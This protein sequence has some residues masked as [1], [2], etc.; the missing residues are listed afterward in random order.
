M[1]ISPELVNSLLKWAGLLAI[2]VGLLIGAWAALADTDGPVMRYWQRY[3]ASL[4]RKL[5][6]MFIWTPGQHIALGQVVASVVVLA[7]HV[8]IGL[9][10]YWWVIILII[11]IA[12][13]RYIEQLRKQR[14]ERIEDQ[15]DGFLTAL[16]NS[17][18]ATPSVG[19]SFISVQPLLPSPIRE[20]IE[21][22]VKEM[23]VGSTL[24]QALLNMGGRI[25]SRQLD[26]A[27]SAVLIG[28]QLGGDLPR[29][30]DTTAQTMREMI[31]L[32]GVVKTKTAEGKAQLW[33]LGAFPFI[34]AVVLST[35][36]PGFY[37]PLKKPVAG[38]AIAAVAGLSWL[39]SI[40][41]ARK[42]LSVDI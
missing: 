18:K 16:A 35:M 9:D 25:N 11:T 39:V 27:L 42:V 1:I 21:L 13:S 8:G 7:L 3:C 20:E 29:I 19:N 31:R 2:F 15:I 37:D 28:R 38:W 6:L 26:T 12:P 4:E 10:P 30:L 24:D 36:E 23:K 5:R 33:V 41:L 34:F 17:L 14:V 32:E 22:C 40:L